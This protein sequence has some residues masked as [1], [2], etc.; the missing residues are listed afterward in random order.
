MTKLTSYDA[1]LVKIQ[2]V[3]GLTCLLLAGGSMAQTMNSSTGTPAN[4]PK[5]A[6]EMTVFQPK[7]ALLAADADGPRL[8]R[9]SPALGAIE[10]GKSAEP[11]PA[12]ASRSASK[13]LRHSMRCNPGKSPN[14]VGVCQ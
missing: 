14:Q 12:L 13:P 5:V 10:A 4:S 3:A 8:Q 6:K 7:D 2:I 1:R 9:R 11:G